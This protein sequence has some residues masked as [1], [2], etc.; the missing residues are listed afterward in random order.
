MS[1]SQNSGVLVTQT[2]DS[3]STQHANQNVLSSLEASGTASG[4]GP[5]SNTPQ[6]SAPQTNAPQ[7]SA[8]QTNTPQ[9]NIPQSSPDR[10][11]TQ[12]NQLPPY[13]QPASTE[14]GQHPYALANSMQSGHA[15]TSH[16]RDPRQPAQS[17]AQYPAQYPQGQESVQQTVS[18]AGQYG[19]YQP[20]SD[21]H[22]LHHGQYQP[23]SAQYSQ[24]QLMYGN[25]HMQQ[26]T[27]SQHGQYQRAHSAFA[28]V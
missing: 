5:Q 1:T 9:T 20:T 28:H 27:T 26:Q 6:T 14:P 23:T 3:S 15:S 24:Q 21:H 11:T 22:Q 10:D 7:T 18:S 25:L 17:T 12:Y 2:V 19:S 16:L 13:E 4:N 8:P